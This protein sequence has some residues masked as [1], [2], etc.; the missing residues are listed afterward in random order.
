[1]YLI[2]KIIYETDA[3]NKASDCKAQEASAIFPAPHSCAIWDFF[4]VGQKTQPRRAF[5]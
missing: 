4:S 1:M 3:N 2:V 5:L